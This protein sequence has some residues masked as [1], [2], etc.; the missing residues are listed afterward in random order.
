MFDLPADDRLSAW[1]QLRQNLEISNTPFED[2]VEFWANSP[3]VPYN[4]N[5][6]PFNQRSWP[7]PWDIIVENQYD[8]F[9]RAL[10]MANTLKLS[11]RFKNDN[12]MIKTMVDSSQNKSYNI[13]IINEEKILNYIDNEVV[14]IKNL[15][16]TFLLENLIEVN[17]PK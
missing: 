15:P 6:D 1:V 14:D 5:V 8:D 12:I 17:G 9:T 13:V 16:P 10:M 4:R 7:T 2:V 3:F 11:T